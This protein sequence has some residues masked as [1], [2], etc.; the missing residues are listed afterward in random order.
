MK[1]M[2][3]IISNEDVQSVT[4]GLIKEKVFFTKLSTTGGLLHSGNTTLLIGVEDEMVTKVEEIVGR[5]SKSRKQKVQMGEPN[6][7][8]VFSN[9]PTSVSISGAT[10]FVLSVDKYTKL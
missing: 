4:K 3:I 7:Y 2:L 10:I 9:F 8:S 6:D 1:L 5:C